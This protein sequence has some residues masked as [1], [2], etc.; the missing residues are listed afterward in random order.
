MIQDI[1]VWIIV[2]AT[3]IY[4][5]YSAIQSVRTKKTG[6]CNGCSA[7]ELKTHYP[8]VRFRTPPVS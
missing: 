2:S 8:D 4:V 7:C 3:V 1:L 5:V 6:R